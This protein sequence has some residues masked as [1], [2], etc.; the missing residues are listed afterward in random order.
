M[1]NETL[2]EWVTELNAEKENSG[3]QFSEEMKERF[4][5]FDDMAKDLSDDDF[6]QLLDEYKATGSTN[7]MVSIMALGYKYIIGVMLRNDSWRKLTPDEAITIAFKTIGRS[8]RI[9]KPGK[10]KFLS[11]WARGVEMAWRDRIS[12]QGGGGVWNDN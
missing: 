7:A 1:K 3:I 10:S 5:A 6:P 8:L 12:K 4:D 11:F 2:N 9:F